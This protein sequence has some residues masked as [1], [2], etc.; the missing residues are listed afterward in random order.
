MF[1]LPNPRSATISITSR[2]HRDRKCPTRNQH[3]AAMLAEMNVLGT[4]VIAER[5]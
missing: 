1:D 3:S 5:E 4:H 2:G